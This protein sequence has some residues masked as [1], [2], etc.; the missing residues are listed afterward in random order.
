MTM[1]T[2]EGSGIYVVTVQLA[3]GRTLEEAGS[4]YEVDDYLD[5][6]EEAETVVQVDRHEMTEA[7]LEAFGPVW[8][9]PGTS[10]EEDDEAPVDDDEYT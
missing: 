5:A 8:D 6:L 3:D 4:E 7:E 2:D 10:P 9:S 1:N